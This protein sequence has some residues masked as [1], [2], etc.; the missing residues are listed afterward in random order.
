MARAGQMMTCQTDLLSYGDMQ[1]V[2]RHMPALT[3]WKYKVHQRQV[4]T[5]WDVR[6]GG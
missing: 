3:E 4:Q 5:R 2:A 6:Y 1:I